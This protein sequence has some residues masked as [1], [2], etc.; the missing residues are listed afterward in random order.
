MSRFD[1]FTLAM[2]SPLVQQT[3]T[4]G[5]T[6]GVPDIVAHRTKIMDIGGSAPMGVAGYG[7]K[8]KCMHR[9]PP[10]KLPYKRDKLVISQ[11]VSLWLLSHQHFPSF[12]SRDLCPRLHL[13]V[14]PA[15]THNKVSLSY[16][17][18]DIVAPYYSCIISSLPCYTV[19]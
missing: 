11:S 12:L 6:Y 16:L 19:L 15:G 14:T 3:G 18:V 8:P 17:C 4:T 9:G 2:A 1:L 5:C 13:C 7:F 10:P